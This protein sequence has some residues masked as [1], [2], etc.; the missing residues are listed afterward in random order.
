MYS[1]IFINFQSP[2][3][4]VDHW[5]S[6]IVI[7]FRWKF[8]QKSIDT[9]WVQYILVYRRISV[10]RYCLHVASLAYILKFLNTYFSEIIRYI[11][12]KVSVGTNCAIVYQ[13]M[14]SFCLK[15][16]AEFML[17]YA[18]EAKCK[19]WRH[20]KSAYITVPADL[21]DHWHKKISHHKVS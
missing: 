12:L 14:D 9:Y 17:D 19:Q 18:N 21:H 15:L 4:S 5:G 16:E 7:G 2:F 20:L 3:A 8:W 11:P 1:G 10:W 13:N 6:F